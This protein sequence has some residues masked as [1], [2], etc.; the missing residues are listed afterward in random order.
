MDARDVLDLT[1]KRFGLKA[2]ELAQASGVTVQMLSR[3]RNK[4]QD[5]Q[6]LNFLEIFRALPYE[7]Q[8]FYLEC[9]RQDAPV[10]EGCVANASR[11][12]KL[13]PVTT[14]ANEK[15]AAEDAED[16]DIEG[17]GN[18]DLAGL[19][20]VLTQ[21]KTD[22]DE[23]RTKLGLDPQ[24]PE[25]YEAVAGSVVNRL[26][27]SPLVQH[28]NITSVVKPNQAQNDDPHLANL[29]ATI[30]HYSST[31]PALDAHLQALFR[32]PSEHQ[33]DTNGIIHRIKSSIG[34]ETANDANNADEESTS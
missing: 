8:D 4:H 21:L 30:K 25:V 24:P 16:K 2:S 7:A 3:Y 19:V 11:A 15:L 22:I 5:M 1:I 12:K 17:S 13:A 18:V 10:A 28:P 14:P 32:A 23:V 6:S 34:D 20:G 33:A 31:Q 9:L 26:G 27:L 29:K